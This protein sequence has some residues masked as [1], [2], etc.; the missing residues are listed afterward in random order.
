MCHFAALSTC[1]PV[2]RSISPFSKCSLKH[3]EWQ[4]PR[5]KRVM[6]QSKP[7]YTYPG[8]ESHG[9]WLIEH[10]IRGALH[11]TWDFVIVVQL[12]S[13]VQLFATAWTT[14]TSLPCP[15][16]SPRVCSDSWPV[17]Q[18]CYLTISSSAGLFSF[19]LQSFPASGSFP[20]SWH[21]TSGGQSIRTSASAS[22]LPMHS[23]GWF[24]LGFT[25][26]ISL[27]FKGL[28]SLLQHHN[29]KAPILQC[30]ALFI[31]QLSYPYMTTGKTRALTIGTFVGKVM[32]L[33][34][35][36]NKLCWECK[37]I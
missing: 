2:V 34:V 3:K 28:S 26:L 19:C 9:F 10:L 14:F 1:L 30:S 5:N 36:F 20:M 32:S 17:S 13:W 25:G 15:S 18:W 22:V 8:W 27:L 37:R 7:A 35:V 12:L 16:V 29:S 21:F 6:L 23:Q 11:I 24:P 31:V 33:R 4:L